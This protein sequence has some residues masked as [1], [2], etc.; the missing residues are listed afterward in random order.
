MGET[1]DEELWT[2]RAVR[3]LRWWFRGKPEEN[4]VVNEDLRVVWL[5]QAAEALCS[6]YST[7]F[8]RA[9]GLILTS[10]DVFFL[11]IYLFFLMMQR[12]GYTSFDDESSSC[13]GFAFTEPSTWRGF[14][15]V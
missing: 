2:R 15:I 3:T 10:I 14:D 1:R 4:N 5:V 13:V 9:Y 8:T 11:F 12:S 7:R 6:V